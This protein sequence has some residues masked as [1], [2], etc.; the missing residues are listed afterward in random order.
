MTEQH[1]E[2]LRALARL[3]DEGRAP[4]AAGFEARA[5]TALHAAVERRVTRGS[6]WS[7]LGTLVRR[8]A[9]RGLG[10]VLTAAAAIVVALGWSAP[11]GSPLHTV[12]LA[13]EAVL[14]DL[15]GS[16]RAARELQYAEDR[17]ADAAAGR[18]PSAS[19]AEAASLLDRAARDLRGRSGPVWD[20]WSHDEAELR[21]GQQGRPTGGDGDTVSGSS[22]GEGTGV[23]AP[24]P[25][26]GGSR[27]SG[28]GSSSNDSGPLDGGSGSTDSSGSS[29]T[30]GG[31]ASSSD[32]GGGSGSSGEGSTSGSSSSSFSSSS[33]GGGGSSSKSGD[34]SSSSSSS[35]SDGGGPDGG[36]SVATT[37]TTSTTG[38]SSGH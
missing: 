5:R 35:S 38:D 11:A 37:T 10:A 33:S 27:T 28:D 16:D 30:S 31:S 9:A 8:P 6:G 21:E 4:S 29:G 24:T 14:L 7:C 26:A 25:S 22:G 20:R 12:R 15:P 36:S 19:L 23:A 3:A 1:D 17:L 32:S 13:R 18:D 34:S 2:I